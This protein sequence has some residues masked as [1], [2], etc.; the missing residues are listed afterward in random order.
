MASRNGFPR[1]MQAAAVRLSFAAAV[2]VTLAGC[3]GSQDPPDRP[4]HVVSISGD[5]SQTPP[6]EGGIVACGRPTASFA[7]LG[8]DEARLYIV[9]GHDFDWER[10]WLTVFEDVHEVDDLSSCDLSWLSAHE[11]AYSWGFGSLSVAIEDR[12]GF[13]HVGDDVLTNGTWTLHVDETRDGRRYVGDVTFRSLGPWQVRDVV[14]VP[15]ESLVEGDLRG[16][17]R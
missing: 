5:L 8:T 17:W 2:I 3:L 9:E 16:F 7:G 15:S 10:S 4:Y 14:V 12:G 6:H 13:L 11:G 1:S